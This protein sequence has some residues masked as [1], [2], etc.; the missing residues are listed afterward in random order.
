MKLFF[1]FVLFCFIQ[2]PSFSQIDK[3]IISSNP[4]FNKFAQFKTDEIKN[5][6]V[7]LQSNKNKNFTLDHKSFVIGNDL[8]K[9]LEYENKVNY[10]VKTIGGGIFSLNAINQRVF[11]NPIEQSYL[12]ASYSLSSRYTNINFNYKNL[13]N[14]NKSNMNLMELNINARF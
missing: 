7:N 10:G 11:G 8:K 13:D 4:T 14:T 3:G 5:L 6:N 1:L 2:T 12:G 9:A